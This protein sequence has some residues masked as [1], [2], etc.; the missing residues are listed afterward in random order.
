MEGVINEHENHEEINTLFTR[1]DDN[2]KVRPAASVSLARLVHDVSSAH[3]VR[4]GN[5]NPISHKF[6]TEFLRAIIAWQRR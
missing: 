2:F 4:G 5:G 6:T 1:D 3:V